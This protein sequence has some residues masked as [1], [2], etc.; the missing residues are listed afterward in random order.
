MKLK[1]HQKELKLRDPFPN[2][3]LFD[4]RDF[5]CRKEKIYQNQK[6]T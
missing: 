5:Y 1:I 2:N 4:I 3:I 6:T